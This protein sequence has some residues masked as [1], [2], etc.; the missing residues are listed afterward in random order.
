MTIQW[1][2]FWSLV[3]SMTVACAGVV[4]SGHI[5][6]RTTD[7]RFG[8]VRQFWIIAG[9]LPLFVPDLLTGFIWRPVS[10]ELMNWSESILSSHSGNS[11]G[12]YGGFLTELLYILL[13]T[14]RATSY[15]VAVRMMMP[16]SNQES[17]SLFLW[18][19]LRHRQKVT[20]WVVHF[21]RMRLSGMWRPAVVAW[22][23]MTLVS[24]QEFETAALMQL[25]RSPIVWTVTLFDAHAA[26]QPL[27]DSLSMLKWPLMI[28][29]GLFI[30]V[31]VLMRGSSTSSMGVP[32][33]VLE[34][35]RAVRGT[36][37]NRFV[38]ACWVLLVCGLVILWPLLSAVPQLIASFGLILA[39][40]GFVVQSMSQIG[41]SLL[42]SAVAAMVGLQSAKL[43]LGQR[44]RLLLWIMLLPGLSGSLIVSLVLLSVFQ[45]SV[46]RVFYDTWL[47]LL[48]GQVL[49]V[50]P[51]AVFMV[52][53][54]NRLIDPAALYLSTLTA[55]ADATHVARAGFQIRWRLQTAAWVVAAM[56]LSHW[57]FWDVTTVSI[58]RPVDLEPVVTRLYN[59]MH[60]GR[61]EILMLMSFLSAASIPATAWLCMIV[62]RV[63]RR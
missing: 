58:L 18:S 21:L 55:K 38:A 24:L 10:A 2:F 8:N 1:V 14:I 22:C 48:A 53:V 57:C 31:F 46:G 41:V 63:A 45:T 51:R 7:H 34:S 42:F 49:V 33:D 9:L 32:D 37:I 35:Q 59:E 16:V 29:G 11:R 23:L 50:L 12:M 17:T 52:I 26:H 25:D 62:L 39:N 28:E 15:G 3:R 13:L 6:A 56:A 19:T 30:P 47:P 43:I 40:P 27:L 60:Y 54:L 20:S 44:S 61:T 36:F 4:L 5:H